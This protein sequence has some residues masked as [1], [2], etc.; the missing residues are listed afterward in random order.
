MKSIIYL[1]SF[2]LL[3]LNTFAQSNI[4]VSLG[5]G[6]PLNSQLMMIQVREG[7]T[8]DYIF[9][10]KVKGIYGSP[11]SGFTLNIAFSRPLVKGSP[12]SWDIENTLLLG[13]KYKDKSVYYNGAEERIRTER[14]ALSY[15]I[16][17]S[18]VYQFQ[19]KNLTPYVRMGPILGFNKI[20]T[21]VN[22]LNQSLTRIEYSYEYT[23]GL[24]LGL[25]TSIGA[26]TK[27]S[28]VTSFFWE[29]SFIN[30]TYTPKKGWLTKYDI[31]GQN[32]LH[33]FSKKERTIKF[34]KE[35]TL[36]SDDEGEQTITTPE[37]YSMGAVALNLGFRFTLGNSGQ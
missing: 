10:R 14:R 29:L 6:L 22:V 5:Y 33:D 23:G 19:S 2:V 8:E 4:R 9:Y 11:G 32:G 35:F 24:S 21:N 20:I 31:E 13:K 12:L 36:R 17:P 30:M 15:Q 3:T 34:E 7:L 1:T 26:F 28:S 37:R 25:K 16:T 27:V 18:L